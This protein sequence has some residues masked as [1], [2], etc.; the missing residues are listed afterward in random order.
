M[1]PPLREAAD[2]AALRG[3][4]KDG[5]IDCIASDHAPHAYD[6][7]EAAFDD[8]P[9]GVVGLETAF[10]VAH[11]ELVDSGV[12]ALPELIRRMSTEPARVFHLPGGTLAPGSIADVAVL[13]TSAKWSVDPAA[14]H[15]KSHN[16]PFTGRG[17]TGRAVLTIVA[18][19]SYT[20]CERT[21]GS[22]HGVVLPPARGTRLDRGAGWQSLGAYRHGPGARHA[23]RF[24][25]GARD[26]W[27]HGRSRP[28]GKTAPAQLRKPTSEL[29]LHL[30][31]LR[32]RPD[33]NAVVHAHP[34]VATGFAVAAK[35]FRATCCRSLRSSWER[36]PRAVRQGRHARV[37]RPRRPISQGAQRV[38]TRKHGAVTMGSTLDEAWIRMETL[39][40]SAR[41]IVAAMRLD[42]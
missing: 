21:R 36:C 26:A 2:V 41:I 4:L 25:Q 3:A 15:S 34:P 39:E 28:R 42:A 17:L 22:A 27:G 31:I 6:E 13:D 16:T 29:D 14:F 33:V 19:P 37:G 38:A 12:F 35:R 8:A 11:T 1:N 10:A 32:H 7:K 30:R 40:H 23:E 9:F 20:S 24:D 18:A 5:V